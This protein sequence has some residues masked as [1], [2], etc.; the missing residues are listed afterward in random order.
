MSNT[1][2]TSYILVSKSGKTAMLRKY[3]HNREAIKEYAYGIHQGVM[4][5]H[6]HTWDGGLKTEKITEKMDDAEKERYA[7]LF[8]KAGLKL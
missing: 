1:P 6:V 7:R 3:D 2:N 8:K 4:Q 5:W